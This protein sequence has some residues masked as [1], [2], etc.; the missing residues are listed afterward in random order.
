MESHPLLDPEDTALNTE[1]VE[2]QPATWSS[3]LP[4]VPASLSSLLIPALETSLDQDA[5]GADASL[6]SSTA[7]TPA[8]P[9]FSTLSPLQY[10]HSV[11]WHAP[12][13][14]QP[15]SV[16]PQTAVASSQV[17]S[18][19]YT[20]SVHRPSNGIPETPTAGSELSHLP[21]ANAGAELA[22][23]GSAANP[24]LQQAVLREQLAVSK[25]QA[26]QLRQQLGAAQETAQQQLGARQEGEGRLTALLQQVEQLLADRAE[27]T[28]EL[29]TVA[30]ERDRALGELGT[31]KVQNDGLLAQ[32]EGLSG[33]LGTAKASNEALQQQ[34]DALEGGTASLQQQ[35]L[36]LSEELA[37][38]RAERDGLQQQLDATSGAA[39][40][41][42]A[43]VAQQLAAASAE[44]E[45]L[46]RRVEEVQV[47]L[48]AAVQGREELE[49][50]RLR[51]SE[52]AAQ[53]LAQVQAGSEEKVHRE[54]AVG[55]LSGEVEAL[56]RQLAEVEGLQQQVAEGESARLAMQQELHDAVASCQQLKEQVDA[57]E[58]EVGVVRE[59]VEQEWRGAVAAV[60][61]ELEQCRAELQLLQGQVCTRAAMCH[62]AASLGTRTR[63]R[64]PVAFCHQPAH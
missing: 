40:L 31:G 48:D 20:Q 35:M 53:L 8:Q 64:E 54:A 62:V 24:A 5:G 60:K 38:V 21:E 18:G 55:A 9:Q 2:Q 11:E 49:A 13:S 1:P 6:A 10:P 12:P 51:V 30:V 44:S 27:L 22:G 45:G 25:A 28:Q 47:A 58:K 52:E 19:G 4:P 36:A 57:A 15:P 3:S 29:G 14:P 16:L 32:V 41:G 42:Q 23:E 26:Q 61:E 33:E 56:R 17:H 7:S 46:R 63:G 50:A 39:V 37:G 43:E 34:L 59:Q